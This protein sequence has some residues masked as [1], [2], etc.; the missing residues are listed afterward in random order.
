MLKD[1]ERCPYK[2]ETP[3][4]GE[5]SMKDN[6]RMTLIALDR[7]AKFLRDE[8][9]EEDTPQRWRVRLEYKKVVD[10]SWMQAEDL[11]E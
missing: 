9:T 1:L 7:Y 3:E 5:W 2:W 10:Y 8:L 11:D 4:C 6:E